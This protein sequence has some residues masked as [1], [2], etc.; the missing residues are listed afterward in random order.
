MN[1][2]TDSV[3]AVAGITVT[4]CAVVFILNVVLVRNDRLGRLWMLAFLTLI[5][6]IA[7]MVASRLNPELW[8]AYGVSNGV[9]VLA[10]ALLWSGL[11]LA[12]GRP[13]WYLL[14]VAL[15][16]VVAFAAL[17]RGPDGGEWAG[18]PA[19]FLGTSLV[20]AIGGLECFRGRVGRSVNAR[21][22]GSVLLVASLY[23]LARL[24]AFVWLGVEHPWFEP[25]FGA[26]PDAILLSSLLVAGTL[27]LSALH[28]ELRLPG[29][30]VG[31]ARR[32]SGIPGV[33]AAGE[34]QDQVEHWLERSV[35]DRSTL[36]FAVVRIRDL[37]DIAIA[38]GRGSAEHAVREVGRLL[39]TRL[40]A[41]SLL[42]RVSGSVYA[43]ILP[44]PTDADVADVFARLETELARSTVD[45][46]DRFRASIALSWTT[47]RAG[48]ARWVDLLAAVG[49]EQ[50][51]GA[52]SD[53]PAVSEPS[54]VS[55]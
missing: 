18:T 53:Q 40:P 43:A 44:L 32:P 46:A 9:F 27:G 38:F 30:D 39:A 49:G 5:L 25:L 29:V 26:I 48:G 24:A 1:L 10:L 42:G 54:A 45:D 47:T 3:L 52:P 7:T 37:D 8:W 6:L 13:S 31:D 14:P 34:F 20:T 35:R 2:N 41:A 36:V 23:Y 22:V 12:N 21:I 11:R 28:A 33:L 17:V 4:I 16:T 19:H 50:S 51:N 15:G 55:R